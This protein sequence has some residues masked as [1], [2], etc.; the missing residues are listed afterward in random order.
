MPLTYHDN[1][2]GYREH[3]RQIVATITTDRPSERSRLIYASTSADCITDSAAGRFVQQN[4]LAVIEQRARYA[5][6][7]APGRR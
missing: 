1:A 3:I 2:V 6:V 4:K 7:L 5:T